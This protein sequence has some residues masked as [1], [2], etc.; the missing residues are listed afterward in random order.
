MKPSRAPS[1]IALILNPPIRVSKG[2]II[3][4]T[5][6]GNRYYALHATKGWRSY[7]A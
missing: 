5:H 2:H 6:I 3:A 7:P 4:I 1:K